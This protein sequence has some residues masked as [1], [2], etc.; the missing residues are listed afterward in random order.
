MNGN[1]YQIFTLEWLF[2]DGKL[3]PE[4]SIT[5]KEDENMMSRWAANTD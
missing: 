5:E 2:D 4:F 3:P 1:E